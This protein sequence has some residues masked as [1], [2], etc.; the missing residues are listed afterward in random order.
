MGQTDGAVIVIR[1]S[2]TGTRRR[3]ADGI[4]EGGGN[5]TV[6]SSKI[7][8]NSAGNGGGVYAELDSNGR[9]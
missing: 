8:G 5:L 2:I 4:F 1:S 7:G 9:R 3:S 6:T